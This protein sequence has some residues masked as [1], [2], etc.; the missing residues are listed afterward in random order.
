MPGGLFWARD[1]GPACARP[2]ATRKNKQPPPKPSQQIAS[3]C[4]PTGVPTSRVWSCRAYM[5]NQSAR[6]EFALTAH[7][8]KFVMR[9]TNQ[10]AHAPGSSRVYMPPQS[11][12]R[13]INESKLGLQASQNSAGAGG[14]AVGGKTP[15]IGSCKASSRGPENAKTRPT[16][17]PAPPAGQHGRSGRECFDKKDSA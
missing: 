11:I 6:P 15:K 7:H 10:R 17:A 3:S 5:L 1:H 8:Q 12:N 13:S 9:T 16:N 2:A 4:A 14:W